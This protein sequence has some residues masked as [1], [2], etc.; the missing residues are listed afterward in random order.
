MWLPILKFIHILAAIAAA[1]ANITYGVWIAGAA[2]E[3][4]VLPFVLRNIAWI[5]RRVANPCYGALLVTGVLMALNLAI[6]LTTPWLLTAMALYVLAALLGVFAYAP[7]SRQQRRIL[8][9]EGF[10]SQAYRQVAHRSTWLGVIA[11]M[12]VL[13]IVLLMV[14]QPA[15]W[16]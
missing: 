2:S 8:E 14:V 9:A 7:V 5:D 10:E 16:G 4:T 11:T 12:D 3:P 13:M 1:G 6:P 15:L